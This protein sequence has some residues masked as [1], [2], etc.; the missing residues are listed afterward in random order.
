MKKYIVFCLF[1]VIAAYG[2]S[3]AGDI[4]EGTYILSDGNMKMTLEMKALPDGKYFINGSG[5]NN[6]GKI[7][8]I[9]DLAEIRGSKLIL[10]SCQMNINPSNN[11][12][13]IKDTAPCV[14]CEP[15]AYVSGTYFKQ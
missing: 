2:Q 5:S 13:E 10:G 6:Q 8:R 7:C 9:G 1:I 15:G 3:Y 11:K 12:F 4:A 14:M